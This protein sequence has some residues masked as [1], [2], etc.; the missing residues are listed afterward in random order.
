MKKPD[1]MFCCLGNGVTVC[2][3]SRLENGDYKNVAHIA[4]CGAVKLYDKKL[5]PEALQSIYQQ[6]RAEGRNFKEKFFQLSRLSALEQMYDRMTLKQYVDRL[7]A[8][9]KALTMDDIYREYIKHE[10]ENCGY[11]M[12]EA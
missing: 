4:A 8:G 3:R 1:L 11:I 2:D 10:C 7:E 9:T 6:A 5:P 12:P